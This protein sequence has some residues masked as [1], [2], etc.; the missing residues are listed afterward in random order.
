[1]TIDEVKEVL[2][3]LEL[4]E[5]VVFENPDYVSAIVGRTE[6][7]RIVYSW[8]KMIKHLMDTDKMTEEEKTKQKIKWDSAM[9]GAAEACKGQG[10]MPLGI[11]RGLSSIRKPQ[12]DWR[13]L[14][15]EFIQ[16]EYNDYSLMPPDKRFE[17]DFFMFDFNDTVEVVNDILFF[18]DT[19]GSMGETAINMCFS[20]IQGAINQ[21]EKHLHGKL[22]FFDHEVAENHYDFDDVNGNVA[23]LAVFGGGGTSFATI[24][25]YIRDHREDFDNINGVIVLTDGYCDYPDEELT[26]GLPV[27]WIYTTPE[28]EHGGEPPFGRSAILDESKFRD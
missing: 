18:V 12:K 5:S 9:L 16:E 17:S 10:N 7:G 2:G 27:L 20:E 22:F 13:V 15:Q 11:E 1:M 3:E 4:N 14:L 21:F 19:S 6:D 24:F 8:E 26:D 28:T 25:K 23:D